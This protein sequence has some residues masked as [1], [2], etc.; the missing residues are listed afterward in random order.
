MISTVATASAWVYPCRDGS[1]VYDPV[2]VVPTKWNS[3]IRTHIVHRS[4]RKR[5]T[6][7]DVDAGIVDRCPLLQKP[8]AHAQIPWSTGRIFVIAYTYIYTYARM[9]EKDTHPARKADFY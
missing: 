5:G 1:V 6:T 8:D 3:G 9:S 2:F 7:L 4:H